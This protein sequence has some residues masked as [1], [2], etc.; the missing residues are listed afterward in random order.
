MIEL[1]RE[2]FEDLV[3]EALDSIPPELTAHMRN[4][5]IV[6]EDD[7]PEDGLLGLYQGV[8]LTERGDWYG[9]VLPDHISIYRREILRICETE[10]DVVDEVR[11]TVVHEIAHHFG[12]DDDRLHELGY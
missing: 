1:T 12:I 3:G 5:V 11:I 8:P 2:A 10:E 6:V 4:V 9:G 7:A